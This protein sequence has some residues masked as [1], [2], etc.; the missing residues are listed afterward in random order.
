MIKTIIKLTVLGIVFGVAAYF[1]PFFLIK[2]FLVMVI[3][4]AFFR[5]L[6]GGRHRSMGHGYRHAFADSIR[7]MSDEE[8]ASFKAKWQGRCGKLS[9]AHPSSESK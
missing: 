6:G 9:N 3:L 4:G 7:N 1:M 8:Y 2:V 5:L